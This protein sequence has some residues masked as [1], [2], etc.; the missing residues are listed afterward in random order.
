MSS[1]SLTRPDQEK[2]RKKKSGYSL[3]PKTGGYSLTLEE[4]VETLTPPAADDNEISQIHGA[5][6]G[7]A[8]GIIKVPEGIFSLGAELMDVA[9]IT[10]DAAARVEQVFDKVN[11][12][13]ETAEKTAAGKITQ[14]LVQIGVPATAAAT[15][16]PITAPVLSTSS[17]VSPVDANLKSST[18][19]S[20]AL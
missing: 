8:S 6:A 7:I 5:M 2:D 13:E 12:F 1:Y 17:G 3:T 15:P 10:T 9:G 20:K 19:F 4:E 16:P 18:P 11:I 14:A